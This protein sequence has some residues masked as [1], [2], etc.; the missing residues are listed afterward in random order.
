MP[1][2]VGRGNRQRQSPLLIFPPLFPVSSQVYLWSSLCRDYRHTD[3][4]VRMGGKNSTICDTATLHLA[5]TGQQTLLV[6]IVLS[7]LFLLI[8]SLSRLP[9]SSTCSP[10]FYIQQLLTTHQGNLTHCVPCLLA[11]LSRIETTR[12][13][14]INTWY[15]TLSIQQRTR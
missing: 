15:N 12:W 4:T 5:R 2:L 7:L 8:Y 13:L 10:C 1:I 14:S 9:F 11:L 3:N 6:I